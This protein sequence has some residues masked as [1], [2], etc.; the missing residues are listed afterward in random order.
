M[1]NHRFID[2]S[3]PIIHGGG[4][5]SPVNISYKDHQM[6][7]RHIAEMLDISLEDIQG[8][9]NAMEELTYINTHCATHF[10]AP[11]H[12]TARVGDQK[13]MTV[14]QVPLE[15]CFNHGVRLDV[16]GK[17]P[18]EDI[19]ESDLKKA[20]EIIPYTIQPMDIVLIRTGTSAFYG[21]E[22]CE[23]KNPGV[24][25]EA[26]IWLADQ[27]AKVVGIDSPCWDRPPKMMLAEIKEGVKGKYMQGHRA[28]GERGMC[29]LEWLTNLDQLPSYGFQICAFPVKIER[30]GAGWVRVVALI[31]E[32]GSEG[33]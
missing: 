29:I 16:I 20:A 12:Y 32:N 1:L 10:D 23:M 5:A 26:T 22:D 33:K 31:K 3:L 18:G 25:R 19:T 14:D 17:Q 7:G 8:Y 30:A 15:W 24:T 4:F 9:A 27:G 11:W 6:R 2:L 21:Q 13:A 28:A